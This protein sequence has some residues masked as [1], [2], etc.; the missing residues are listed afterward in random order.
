MGVFSR[1]SDIVNSNINSMLDKAEDPEKMVSMII[2]EMNETLV[3]VRT[4]AAKAIADKKRLTRE[5][6]QRLEEVEHWQNQAE[7]AI[8]KDR[9]DLARAALTERKK[10][11]HEVEIVSEELKAVETMLEKLNLDIQ[12]LDEKLG[13]AKAR[14]EAILLRGQTAQARLG[15]RKQLSHRNIDDAMERFELYERQMD[16]LEG[17]VE[18]FDVGKKS[19]SEEIDNLVVDEEIESDLEELKRSVKSD[20]ES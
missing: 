16:D 19:L 14:K 15:V 18:S 7:I 12:T 3:E 13:E 4:T 8:R 1:M 6:R 9:D 10:A 2:R 11:E 17:K 5:N 20:G